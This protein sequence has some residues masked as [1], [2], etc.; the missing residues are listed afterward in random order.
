MARSFFEAFVSDTTAL[1]FADAAVKATIML[2]LALLIAIGLRRS[3]AAIRHRLWS[4]SLCGVAALPIMSWMIPGWR[5]PVLPA[6]REVPVASTSANEVSSAGAKVDK[7][8]T[9]DD[10]RPPDLD[11]FGLGIEPSAGEDQTEN[12]HVALATTHRPVGETHVYA[13]VASPIHVERTISQ[14]LLLVWAIGCIGVALPTL[15]GLIANEWRRRRSP[16]LTDAGLLQLLDSLCRV[17]ALRRTVELRTT[18]DSLAPQTWGIFRPVILLP[19][20]AVSWP[21][22][23]RRLVLLHELAHIERFDMAFQLAGRMAAALYWFHP[24]AWFGLHRLRVESEHSCDDYVV[25]LGA[26]PTDYAGQLLDLARSLRMPRLSTALSMARASTLEQRVRALFDERISHVPLGRR[27]AKVLFTGTAVVML[28]LAAVHPGSSVAEPPTRI[29]PRAATATTSTPSP[30]KPKQP[31]AAADAKALDKT[32]KANPEPAGHESDTQPVTVTG[33]A[34]DR[35]GKPIAGAQ[36]YLASVDQIGKRVAD[37]KTDVQGRFAFHGVQL[38]IQNSE[39]GAP[40]SVYQV[41]G[42]AA[43]FGFAWHNE[44]WLMMQRPTE[45]LKNAAG[46]LVPATSIPHATNGNLELDVTFPRAATLSGRVVNDRGRP[47]PLARVVIRYC[48]QLTALQDRAFLGLHALKWDALAPPEM[49]VR[50]TDK[51]GRFEFTELPEECQ[52]EIDVHAK[53]FYVR[54]FWAATTVVPQQDHEGHPVQTGDLTLAFPKPAILSGKLVDDLGEPIPDA[55]VSIRS[56]EPLIGEGWTFPGLQ[57]STVNESTPP[58]LQVRTTLHSPGTSRQVDSLP[59]EMQARTTNDK[60][61]FEFIGLPPDYR[62]E[63]DAMPPGF[64]RKW[65]CAATTANAQ[66]PHNGIPVLTGELTLTF[67]TPVDVPIQVIFGDTGQPASNARVCSWEGVGNRAW[68]SARQTADNEGRVTLR[69]APGMRGLQASP[70]PGSRYLQYGR[71][72]LIDDGGNGSPI[73]FE[74]DG[75]DQKPDARI[76]FAPIVIA[77]RQASI[78]DATVVDSESGVAIPDVGLWTVDDRPDGTRLQMGL[79]PVGAWDPDRQRYYGP[80][81]TDKNGKLR[82]LI[83]PGKQRITALSNNILVDYKPADPD[84]HEVECTAGE[85]IEVKFTM[86]K[87]G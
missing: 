49:T 17:L 30:I 66:P 84:V 78:I 46:N 31:I 76:A 39:A 18:G 69:L 29:A 41:F 42:R 55:R 45:N 74:P 87:R 86:K 35:D 43:G 63:I 36:I 51:N 50:N 77:L 20:E 21:E 3:S 24:L 58:E 4:L 9:R 26:R 8:A 14:W 44:R 75:R 79:A 80:M 83:D 22:A 56:A 57:A 11:H 2:S 82:V 62:F 15:I 5:L 54:R 85:T 33:R 61:R 67:P 52:F 47:L 59:P 12:H 6:L 25:Q 73:A 7:L 10:S 53:G 27:S 32:D 72:W 19:E 38:P 37:M 40:H 28:G 64:L 1:A 65:I 13:V 48:Q 16:L 23:A 71:G 34:L 60:G 81:S 68:A 70:A